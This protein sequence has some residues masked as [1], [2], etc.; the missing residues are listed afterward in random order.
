M[1]HTYSL[2]AFTIPQLFMRCENAGISIFFLKRRK[3]RLLVTISCNHVSHKQLPTICLISISVW[4]HKQIKVSKIISQ[5]A[6]PHPRSEG[7]FWPLFEL[8]NYIDG[9]NANSF[10]RW[11]LFSCITH[12]ILKVKSDIFKHFLKNFSPQTSVP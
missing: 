6:F 12:W 11:N 5:Q 9:T 10:S 8:L 3:H 2:K 4:S 7:H 1:K